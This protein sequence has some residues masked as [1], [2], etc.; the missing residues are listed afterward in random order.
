MLAGECGSRRIWPGPRV[1][2][3]V[4]KALLAAAS[5]AIVSAAVLYVWSP[6]G[7]AL[8]VTIM[9]RDLPA[10]VQHPGGGA[11]GHGNGDRQGAD[12]LY[13]RVSD[14]GGDLVGGTVSISC[15]GVRFPLAV[16]FGSDGLFRQELHN[17]RGTCEFLLRADFDGRWYSARGSVN[18]APGH[19]YYILATLKA[20]GFFVAFPTESY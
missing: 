3:S 9:K 18:P 6:R 16:T 5:L 17:H 4:K 12:V 20:G 19:A 13:G 14:P 11:G 10:S 7:E 15:A 1:A 2:G 8:A